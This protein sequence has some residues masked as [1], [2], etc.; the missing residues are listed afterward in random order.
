MFGRCVLILA[1]MEVVQIVVT[2]HGPM[3]GNGAVDSA[4]AQSLCEVG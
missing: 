1:F 4:Q 2:F 3:A